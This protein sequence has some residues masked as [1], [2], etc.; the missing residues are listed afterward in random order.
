MDERRARWIAGQN[1]GMG[2]L[3]PLQGPGS[4]SG[5]LT[6]DEDWMSFT[7]DS[8]GRRRSPIEFPLSHEAGVFPVAGALFSD[9]SESV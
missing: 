3:I 8:E 4:S 1:A 5:E 6:G 2:E 7:L 9:P